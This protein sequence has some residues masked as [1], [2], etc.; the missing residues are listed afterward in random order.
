MKEENV[1]F[2]MAEWLLSDEEKE[3]LFVRMNE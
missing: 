2:P 3:K 1:L